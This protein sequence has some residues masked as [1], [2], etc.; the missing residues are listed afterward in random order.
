V[1]R[2]YNDKDLALG[3]GV[4]DI[5]DAVARLHFRVVVIKPLEVERLDLKD[6][7]SSR[8]RRYTINEK[9]DWHEEELWP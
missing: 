7:K 4:E 1:T 3:S 9:Y 5:E 6:P 2:P 8:R